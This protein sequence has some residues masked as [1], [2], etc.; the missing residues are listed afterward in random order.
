M[1]ANAGQGVMSHFAF[2]RTSVQTERNRRFDAHEL[3]GRQTALIFAA[4]CSKEHWAEYKSLA[5]KYSLLSWEN[6]SKLDLKVSTGYVSSPDLDL[7]VRT[8]PGQSHSLEAEFKGHSYKAADGCELLGQM[9]SSFGKSHASFFT[10]LIPKAFADDTPAKR[11][12]EDTYGEI[13]AG[14]SAVIGIG[15]LSV[16]CWPGELIAGGTWLGYLMVAGLAY[17]V[18]SG[19]SDAVHSYQG[20][21]LKTAFENL[22]NG[23]LSLQCSAGVTTIQSGDQKIV[24]RKGWNYSVDVF[25]AKDGSPLYS[26]HDL[27][28]TPQSREF[29]VNVARKCDTPEQA[30]AL[31]KQFSQGLA[32]A[33]M[34]LAELSQAPSA[35]S[36]EISAPN[37]H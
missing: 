3:N 29:I 25:N 7:Q 35:A 19:L 36:P 26:D 6:R 12:S 24:V 27:A 37:V 14:V 11:V 34:K 30:D 32:D 9:L 8:H 31:T 17:E 21:K 16:V 28:A 15:V 1:P 22:L 13:V 2:A 33:K 20:V 5:R 4:T 10:S 18:Y 23:N